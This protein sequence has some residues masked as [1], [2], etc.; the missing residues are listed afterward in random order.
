LA[1]GNLRFVPDYGTCYRCG[2]KCDRNNVLLGLHAPGVAPPQDKKL[3]FECFKV[4]FEAIK[5]LEGCRVE[6]EV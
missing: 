1:D 3:C 6:E 2:Q 5:P 4:I